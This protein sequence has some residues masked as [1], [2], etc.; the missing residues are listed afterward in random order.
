MTINVGNL[1][2]RLELAARK[3]ALARASSEMK[4]IH[5]F[6][7][8]VKIVLNKQEISVH[9]SEL[10]EQLINVLASSY[11]EGILKN[12]IDDLLNSVEAIRDLEGSSR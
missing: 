2:E 12:K 7:R 4:P 8:Q 6:G 11:V 1:Q 3:E 5:Y 10:G 9:S